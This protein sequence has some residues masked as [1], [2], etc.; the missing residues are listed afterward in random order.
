[1]IQYLDEENSFADDTEVE[2]SL[3]K[4]QSMH[5]KTS[6]SKRLSVGPNFIIERSRTL[7]RETGQPSHEP[8]DT[9]TIS[10]EVCVLCL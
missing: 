2:P 1:M 8:A 4:T 3:K 5:I 9:S 10:D 7:K 6:Q